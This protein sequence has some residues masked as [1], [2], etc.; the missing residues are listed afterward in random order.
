MILPAVVSDYGAVYGKSCIPS[1]QASASPS[2]KVGNFTAFTSSLQS[3]AALHISYCRN[4]SVASPD[5]K[6]FGAL[7][8]ALGTCSHSLLHVPM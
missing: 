2:N 6:G 1:D 7:I 3:F 4:N 5:E 8:A